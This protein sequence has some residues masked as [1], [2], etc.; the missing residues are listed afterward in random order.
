MNEDFFD[1]LDKYM[2][3]KRLNDN[4]VTV[5]TGIPV[6]SL[7]KQRKGARGLSVNSIAKILY[8]YE[9]LSAD[10]LITG[11]GEM[12]NI[13]SQVS[14]N[15]AGDIKDMLIEAQKEIIDAHHERDYYKNLLDDH[16]ISTKYNPKKVDSA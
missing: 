12:L 15:N 9:D 14:G 5:Q 7:G 11:R 1:R 16:G 10:W 13:S 8:A 3:F 6:G 4:K 2:E